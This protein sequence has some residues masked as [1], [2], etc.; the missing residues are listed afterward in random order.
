[1]RARPER[2]PAPFGLTPREIEVLGLVAGGD[3]NREIA[4]RLFISE[5]TVGIHVSHILAKLGVANRGA[6]AAVAHRRGL[7]PKA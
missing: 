3:T 7:L 4:R 5:R 1:M 6:A 2:A